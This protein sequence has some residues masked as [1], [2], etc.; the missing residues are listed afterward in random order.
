MASI[1]KYENTAG[2]TLYRVRYR[3]PDH[4]NTDK[5]GF[6][7]KRDAEAFLNEIERAKLR[8]EYIDEADSRVLIEDLGEQWLASKQNAMKASSYHSL[9]VSWNTHVKPK[10][11]NYRL[12]DIRYND[13]QQWVNQLSSGSPHS[14]PPVKAKSPTVV[15][16]AEGI[17]L[18]ILR[19]AVQ[20]RR[21]LSNPAEG[22]ILPRKKA[23]EHVY[24]SAEELMNLAEHCGNHQTLVL[25]LGLC[26][27]RWGE[28]AG[29]R[30][31]DVDF[32]HRTIL[33]AR[34]ATMVGN[35]IIIDSP[36]NGKPRKIVWPAILEPGL[37]E[38][39]T[40][41]RPSDLLFTEPE[42]DYISRRRAA[43]KAGSWFNRAL[44]ETGLP[45]M[46]LHDLR[47]TAASLMVSAGANVK[48]VQ[49]QLGHAK[50][51]MTLD[52]YSDL[53]ESD[54]Q[55]VSLALNQIVSRATVGKMWAEPSGK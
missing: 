54:L 13:I 44:N 30:V 35:R 47:H 18:G 48:A 43:G 50:A 12:S 19:S 14:R 10:W 17:L 33:V 28:A 4:T 3:K 39:V 34:S 55:S 32:S 5:R 1:S 21:I 42:G 31:E 16:R 38:A 27:L 37:K 29:L 2:K 11:G 24:L 36:K 53:F 45:A 9:E 20:D 40:G 25:V 22:I 52:V 23:K 8:G 46:S 15:I 6:A 49:R 7:R 51:S 41:K 26:G